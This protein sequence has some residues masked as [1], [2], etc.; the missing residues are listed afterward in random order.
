MK[1]LWEK[2]DWNA[3]QAFIAVV[4]LPTMIIFG[5]ITILIFNP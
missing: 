2:I 4:A 1:S 3:L 5:G